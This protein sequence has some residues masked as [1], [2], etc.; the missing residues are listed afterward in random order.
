MVG[1]GSND[2]VS[3]SAGGPFFPTQV[4]SFPD[5]PDALIS[6][7]LI[8]ANDCVM[9]Q[10]PNG[11][12]TDLPLWPKGF[13]LESGVIYDADGSRVAAIGD[14]VQ[15]GGGEV[16]LSVASDH[17]G[18]AIPKRCEQAALWLINPTTEF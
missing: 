2:Q 17:T 5:Y 8:M 18:V 1:C 13:Y 12:G 16:D 14:S 11:G 7:E 10:L 3:P 9:V 15:L 6:G 4:R